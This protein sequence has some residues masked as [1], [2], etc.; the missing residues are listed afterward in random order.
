MMS[1]LILLDKGYLLFN[2]NITDLIKYQMRATYYKNLNKA[3][4]VL[5]INLINQ[6][7]LINFLYYKLKVITILCC[8]NIV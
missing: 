2:K 3:K 8:L 7:Y 5:L 4:R 1:F 6:K